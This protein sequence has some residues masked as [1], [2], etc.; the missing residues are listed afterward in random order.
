M[1]RPRTK[2][3]LLD[4][5][6]E[7]FEDLF[8]MIDALSEE[9]RLADFEYKN[10]R[11]KNIRDILVHLH[12]WHLL[13]INWYNIWLTW[14]KPIMPAKWYTWKMTKELNKFIWEKYQTISYEES[15]ELINKSFLQI[16]EIIE[17]HTDRELFTKKEYKWTWITSLWAYLV[18]STSS[19]YDWAM[20]S[21]NQYIIYLKKNR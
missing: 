14:R 6:E 7:N 20:K 16:R 15:V 19:H 12:H 5:S 17:S 13:M 3:D 10:N 1:S 18:S 9:E 2:Q 21:L 4:L 8:N 11:D